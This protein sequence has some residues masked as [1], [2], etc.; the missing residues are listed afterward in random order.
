MEFCVKS[1]I[2]FSL[3]LSS[4]LFLDSN[5]FGAEYKVPPTSSTSSSVPVISDAAM[6]QCVKIYNEGEWLGEDINRTNVD[7]YSQ[8]SID[9]Y[10]AKVSRHTNMINYFNKE[11][12]GKQSYSAYKAAKKLNQ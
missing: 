3:L 4:I 11:C 2:L 9:S 6:E 5:A 1:K 7:Q 12:A 10:N 8:S